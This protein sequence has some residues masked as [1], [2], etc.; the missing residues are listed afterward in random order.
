M[1]LGMFVS[2]SLCM[3]TVANALVMSKVTAT[4]RCGG[5]GLLKP[6][7][8]WWQIL[9]KAVWVECL[10]LI[11]VDEK[12]LKFFLL[13]IVIVFS[14]VFWQWVIEVIWIGSLCQCCGLYLV[15]EWG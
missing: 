5:L 7:V 15:L 6:V 14:L 3:C 1:M 9:C 11:H 2:V 12:S 13:C 4:V 10:C 8:I